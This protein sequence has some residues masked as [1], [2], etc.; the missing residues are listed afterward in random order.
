[1]AHLEVAGWSNM[2]VAPSAFP[3]GDGR[4]SPED[5]P[6]QCRRQRRCTAHQPSEQANIERPERVELPF[7]GS[8]GGMPETDQAGGSVL[9]SS[10]GDLDLVD[11]TWS[12][13]RLDPPRRSAFF[14]T[15]GDAMCAEV[16]QVILC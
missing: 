11:P 7:L 14:R 8:P 16:A 5:W 10:Q 1:M 6:A 4:A 15:G 9:R 13:Y 2:S 3:E 12:Q